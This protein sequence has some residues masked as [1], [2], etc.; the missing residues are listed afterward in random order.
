[1]LVVDSWGPYLSGLQ[2]R[3]DLE[4]VTCRL[5]ELGVQAGGAGGKHGAHY[6]PVEMS[7]QLAV[8]TLAPLF[9]SP[10][11][12][13]IPTVLDPACGDGSLLI[14]AREYLALKYMDRYGET[15]LEAAREWVEL[16]C[17]MGIDLDPEAIEAAK[18]RM[19]NCGFECADA[20]QVDCDNYGSHGGFQAIVMNPP[21]LGGSK[22]SGR[23]GQSYRKFLKK[24]HPHSHGGADLC[25]HFLLRARDL[26]RPGALVGAIC[27]NTISQG[28]TRQTGLQ[29]L[30][31]DDCL[32]YAADRDC[33]WGGDAKVTVS[34]IWMA[35][36]DEF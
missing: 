20:F 9:G 6:T 8:Y 31:A 19:P 25:A 13:G 15:D 27:T 36:R 33:P 3:K 11:D 1:M 30:L 21:F 18:G 35:M 24:R 32:I 28:K 23:L 34:L 2:F 29:R 26:C 17:L 5:H 12:N 4:T 16:N 7:A 14:A 22:I 10:I